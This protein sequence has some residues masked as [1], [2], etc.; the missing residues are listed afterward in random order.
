MSCSRGG[1]LCQVPDNCKHQALLTPRYTCEIFVKISVLH[2]AW[3]LGLQKKLQ[4]QI[5]VFGSVSPCMESKYN[6]AID[7]VCMQA[8][9]GRNAFVR[10]ATRLERSL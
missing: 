9:A 3:L 5:A 4:R 2:C 1:C 7:T 6:K 8:T 10:P